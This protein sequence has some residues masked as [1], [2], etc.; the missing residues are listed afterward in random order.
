M[1]LCRYLD[2]Y[3]LSYRKS[4]M[5]TIFPACQENTSTHLKMAAIPVWE[6]LAPEPKNILLPRGGLFQCNTFYFHFSVMVNV[7]RERKKINVC[8][9]LTKNKQ[10]N[11]S[12]VIKQKTTK[13][14]VCQQLSL[15]TSSLALF[16]KDATRMFSLRPTKTHVL[17]TCFSLFLGSFSFKNKEKKND[18]S[19]S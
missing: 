15:F 16:L 17:G 7:E 13:I 2:D 18:V 4:L 19:V 11:T 10:I 9:K 3:I 8:G 12:T 14:N 1:C 6:P 5:L